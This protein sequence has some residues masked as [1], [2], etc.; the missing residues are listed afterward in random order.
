MVWSGEISDVVVHSRVIEDRW[1]K[2]DSEDFVIGWRTG[3]GLCGFKGFA[4][5]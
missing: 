4:A 1:R 3:T 5:G 2:I